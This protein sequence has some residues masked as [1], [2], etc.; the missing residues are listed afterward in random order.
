MKIHII[1]PIL[2][3]LMMISAL[4]ATATIPPKR[5]IRAVWLTTIG[6]LDWP[7][8]YAHNGNGI[9]MQKAE[10]VRILDKLQHAGIN[11]ILLQTRIRA[12][13]IYPS[14]LEP[15]DGC[16]SGNPGASPGYDPLQ[17]AIDEAHKRGMELHAWVVTIPAGKWNGY[18]CSQL[19]KRHSNLLIK[20]GAEGYLNPE[21]SQTADYLADICAEITR[22]Y[23]I[24]GIHLDYI[25]YPETWNPRNR[26][27]GRSCITR[28][29][30]TIHHR[31]KSI[32]PWVKISSAPI[33]KAQDL[34]RYSSHGWNAYEKGCQDVQQWLAEGL[35]DQLYPMMYFKD[36]QFFPF[37]L[38]WKEIA[39]G[40]A[41]APGL[42]IYFLHPSEGNWTLSQVE[43]QMNVL[44]NNG[45]GHTYFRSRF[46]T[47]NTKGIYRFAANHFDTYPTLIPA[48]THDASI[49]NPQAPRDLRITADGTYTTLTWD[50]SDDLY[51]NIYSS[52]IA[53]VDTKDPR[54]LI[55]IRQSRPYITFA[56]NMPQ[57]PF[58]ITAM[59]RYG[60]ESE[61][62]QSH[63][64][65]NDEGGSSLLS[66]QSLMINAQSSS[67][68][69]LPSIVQQ[70]D[71]QYI[72]IETLQGTTI[73]V[74]PFNHSKLYV[75]KLSPG[76]YVIRTIGKKKRK[77][78]IGFLHIPLPNERD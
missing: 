50:G 12:T 25:R 17:F 13:L 45:L 11:T 52:P 19:R 14:A 59:N 8:R 47:D 24:D 64:T 41:V 61:P 63:S 56:K 9:E 1:R 48:I 76:T 26:S 3:F 6:G 57:Q 7:S 70:L 67:F 58:A 37:A 29:V 60:D 20:K 55:A 46:F 42:G 23:D 71:A 75:K 36:N 22:N 5:E 44:R 32:K 15:W 54:N 53:P 38:D 2:L 49:G 4:H 43:R 28:I 16:M 68:V 35:M 21:N 69:T 10:L 65:S 30:R 77:H 39:Q 73:D 31:V 78:R 33:G 62:L 74:R 27:Y 72:S 18:G 40:T 51:Y 66:A 34:S